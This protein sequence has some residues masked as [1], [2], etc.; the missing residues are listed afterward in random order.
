MV[1]EKLS[2]FFLNENPTWSFSPKLLETYKINYLLSEERIKI[3]DA[4]PVNILFNALENADILFKLTYT[5]EILWNFEFNW[6][7]HPRL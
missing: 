3:N 2:V 1:F 4:K 5:Q 7:E 6:S